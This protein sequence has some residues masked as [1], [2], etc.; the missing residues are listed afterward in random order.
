MLCPEAP[1]MYYVDLQNGWGDPATDYEA[2]V[3]GQANRAIS[4]A[5]DSVRGYVAKAHYLN[6]SGRPSEALGVTD[7]GLAINPNFVALYFP[8]PSPKIPSAASSRRRPMRS[9]RCA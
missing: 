2:K 1:Q 4:L 6:M 5:P 7:A 3:F 9:G 8:A